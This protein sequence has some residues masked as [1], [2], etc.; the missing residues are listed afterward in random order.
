MLK[1]I[2]FMIFFFLFCVI[3]VHFL[4][5]L[6]THT[7]ILKLQADFPQRDLWRWLCGWSIPYTR[8]CDKWIISSLPFKVKKAKLW[9]HWALLCDTTPPHKVFSAND[10]FAERATATCQVFWVTMEFRKI[11]NRKTVDKTVQIYENS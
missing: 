8:P 4:L 9:V 6:R 1:V 10:T 11:S 2:P 5:G 3:T 7:H